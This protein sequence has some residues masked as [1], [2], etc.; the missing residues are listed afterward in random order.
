MV[1]NGKI[2]DVF[3]YKNFGA[4]EV[5]ELYSWIIERGLLFE[6]LVNG[7]TE[8]FVWLT[9]YDEYR[10]HILIHFCPLHGVEY[11]RHSSQ[12]LKYLLSCGLDKSFGMYYDCLTARTDSRAKA[13]ILRRIG[14]SNEVIG[15]KLYYL[16][17]REED[18]HGRITINTEASTCTATATA[19]KPTTTE[20]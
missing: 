2:K 10:K 17:Y 7:S 16:H 9:D 19:T 1:Y 14:F 12:I 6:T 5:K 3:G 8:G 11:K 13:R 18:Y 20:S 4:K 15:N